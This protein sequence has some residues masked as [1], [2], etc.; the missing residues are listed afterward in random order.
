[1]VK[2]EGEKYRMALAAIQRDRVNLDRQRQQELEEREKRV[3]AVKREFTAM[4]VVAALELI[5]S[6]QLNV[7]NK[8]RINLE[9]D[10]K[11]EEDSTLKG[12][13]FTSEGVFLTLEVYDKFTSPDNDEIHKWPTRLVVGVKKNESGSPYNYSVGIYHQPLGKDYFRSAEG[14]LF[15]KENGCSVCFDKSADKSASELGANTQQEIHDS[16]GK[17][18]D[19]YKQLFH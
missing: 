19:T 14:Q 18:V 3:E 6:Q 5:N 16:L 10:V 7:H 17:V 9:N 2:Q 1:M 13:S 11:T 15:M 8:G 12:L 4:G